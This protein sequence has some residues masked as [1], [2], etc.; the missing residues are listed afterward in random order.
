MSSYGMCARTLI[1]QC[2]LSVEVFPLRLS[3]RSIYAGLHCSKHDSTSHRITSS[4]VISPLPTS[5]AKILNFQNGLQQCQMNSKSLPDMNFVPSSQVHKFLPNTVTHSTNFATFDKINLN[6]SCP[7]SH[8]FG[9]LSRQSSLGLS[10]KIL[11]RVIVGSLALPSG[12]AP[13]IRH[14]S[15]SK[16][17]F[18]NIHSRISALQAKKRTQRKKKKQL[19]D[20]EEVEEAV[21]GFAPLARHKFLTFDPDFTLPEMHMHNPPPREWQVTAY[22]TADEYDLDKLLDG[23]TQQGLYTRASITPGTPTSQMTNHTTSG[24]PPQAS[25]SVS[26]LVPD[27]NDVL[28]V[29]ATYQLESE[30]R[31]IYFFKE[32]SVVFWNVAELERANVLRFLKKYEEGKYNEQVVEEESE[33]L[34]YRYN[35][36]PSKT[37]LINDKI[38]LNP[39][40]RTDLE[41]YTFSNSMAMS[42]KLGIWESSLDKYID[43]IEY[44]SEELS[45]TGHV[46]LS[47]N[48]V[49]QRMGQL[50]ALRHLINLS[51]D[52]LDVPDFYWDHEDLELLYKRVSDHLSVSKRTSV[53]NV[54]LN[55]CIELMELLKSHLSEQHASRLEWIIIILIMV[56]VAFELL[57]FLE[58]LF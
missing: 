38:N 25:S 54:K 8:K 56:E 46:V 34:A 23:L 58:R 45:K 28:H 35:E 48:Q 13:N 6:M 2:G 30:Q 7:W 4:S 40:G 18:T 53:M 26:S 32:G 52:L 3:S 21:T 50:F 47:Q 39:E 12:M 44:V 49:L 19:A 42:V 1:R 27:A 17:G 24:N 11:N 37:R 5:C 31:E 9:A 22:A 15:Q 29:V 57:H 55:H 43:N 16:G 41:K 36:G 14:L 51:S 33:I 20:S 10:S